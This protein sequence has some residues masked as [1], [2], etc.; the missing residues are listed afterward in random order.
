[1]SRVTIAS[2]GCGANPANTADVATA[3]LTGTVETTKLIVI[4]VTG[5]T[6]G[7]ANADFF[8]KRASPSTGTTIVTLAALRTIINDD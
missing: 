1:M 7:E 2:T 6:L 8:V 3:L 4:D 5:D